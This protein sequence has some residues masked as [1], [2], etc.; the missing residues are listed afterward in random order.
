MPTVSAASPSPTSST[1]PNGSNGKKGLSSGAA[2]ATG[3]TIGL[4]LLSRVLGVVRDMVLTSHFGQT[5]ETTIFTAA[6]RVPDLIALVIAGG[7]LSSVFVPVFTEYWNEGKEEDSWKVFGSITSIA[8]VAVAGLVILMEL[9]AE[10]MTRLLNPNFVSP[11]A[12]A[13]TTW[14]SRILLPAQWFLLVGGLVM[15]T[16]YAR[17]RF[18]VPGLAPLFYNLGQIIGGVIGGML[19]PNS[20]EGL[21]FM[22]WGAT[23]GAFAGSIVLP[24]WDLWRTRSPFRFSLD[25]SHPGVRRVGVLMV[26]VLLGQS[27]GPLNIWMTGF[28]TGEDARLSAFRIAYNLT[29]APIGIF[30]Q[31]FA[32]VLL[33][34]ISALATKKDWPSF[35]SAISDGLRRVLFLTVPASVLMAALAYPLI[36]IFFK[37]GSFTEADVPLAATALIGYSLATFAWSGSSILQRGFWALQDTRTPI[38][39]TTPLVF[40]FLATGWVYSLTDPKG[41]IGFP[42]ATSFYGTVSMVLFL[43]LLNRRLRQD[44]GIGLDVTEIGNSAARIL[45][46]SL[47]SGAVTYG[48]CRFLEQIPLFLTKTGSILIVLI[49][50]GIGIIVYAALALAF[51]MPELHGIKDM[52][53]RRSVASSDTGTTAS[54]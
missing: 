22:A 18:L 52:F 49:A 44:E 41:A 12:I 28:F 38:Y 2:R 23:L 40:A 11:E 24:C 10:P 25:T 7:A 29:Q 45:I 50:G 48:L 6:F 31:A 34:T 19:R 43:F 35:R 17:K 14:L 16:L 51:R 4:V 26:P 27:L 13:S 37:A 46:A 21:A 42:L 1:A 8:A 47:L 36:R 32:I 54:E 39:I 33:P 53:R 15:G 5:T 20:I 30:A 9:V 3:L